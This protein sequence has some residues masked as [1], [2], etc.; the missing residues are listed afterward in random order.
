MAGSSP[1][2]PNTKKRKKKMRFDLS[3]YSTVAERLAQFHQDHPDGRIVTEWENHYEDVSGQRTWVIKAY[4]YPT[5]GDQA[6]KL[7]KSTGYAF[8][9][10]G[11]GGANATSALENAETSAIGRCLMVMGY[12]MNKEPNALASREEMEKVARGSKDYIAEADKLT[13]KDALRALWAEAK[14]KNAPEGVLTYIKDRANATHGTSSVDPGATG[15]VPAVSGKP[16]AS[17]AARTSSRS[18]GSR[19]TS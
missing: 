4:A 13:D 11:T 3:K 12:S 19:A 18:S 9:K 8:E 16:D 6:N 15:G 2:K 7:P 1:K 10:D 17:P 14:S 5:A